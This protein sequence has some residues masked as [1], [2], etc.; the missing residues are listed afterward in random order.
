M[1]R[2]KIRYGILVFLSITL[3]ACQTRKQNYVDK[4]I[5]IMPK[6]IFVEGGTFEMGDVMGDNEA[7]DETVHNVTLSSFEIGAYEVSFTEFDRF[8]DDTG[9]HRSQD[10]GWGRDSMPVVPITWYDA[11]CYCNWLSDQLGY[12][13][14]YTID[15]THANPDIQAIRFEIPWKVSANWESNGFRLPTEAEWEFASRE[16]GKKIRFGNGQNIAASS[17]MNFDARLEGKTVYSESGETRFKNV[18]V[19]S[20]EPNDLGIY[21][22]TGNVE[23]WCWD[24]YTS[25]INYEAQ[26][27]NGPQKGRSKVSRGGRSDMEPKFCRTAQRTGI[28]PPDYCDQHM[29]FRLARN[30]NAEKN[31]NH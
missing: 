3:F 26:N 22:M 4:S 13:P 19:N 10:F 8:C 21:N 28:A 31:E 5:K 7:S 2:K 23:E 6:M 12:Q 18:P 9:Y 17:Q 14:V 1:L 15:T 29:G 30:V 25:N 24:W 27:P 16:R 11:I 20:F